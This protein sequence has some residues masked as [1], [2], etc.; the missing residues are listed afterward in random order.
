VDLSF[1]G[2]R[3]ATALA[4]PTVAIV[5]QGGDAGVLVPNDR[6]QPVFRPVTVGTTVD[7]QTQILEGVVE[8]DRVF[9]ELPPDLSFENIKP[10]SSPPP[11]SS[12]DQ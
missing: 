12:T 4:V 5:T 8:G 6:D 1:V 7:D 9:I 11:D 3:L 2:D 10:E